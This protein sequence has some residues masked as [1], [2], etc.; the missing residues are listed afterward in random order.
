MIMNLP[1]FW[2]RFPPERFSGGWL[3]EAVASAE[4][5]VHCGEC[6]E[7]CPYQ[8][9]IQEMLEENVDFFERV[10]AEMGV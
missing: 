2:K 4:A 5:C 1:S 3:A 6:E 9:P 8:L 10:A 7:K